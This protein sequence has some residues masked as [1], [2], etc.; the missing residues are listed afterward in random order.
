M[1][2]NILGQYELPKDTQGDFKAKC[3]HCPAYISGSLKV[4]SNFKTDVKVC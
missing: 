1:E 4:T 2:T 3:R